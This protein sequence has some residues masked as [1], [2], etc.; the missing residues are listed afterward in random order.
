MIS[1]QLLV[2][3]TQRKSLLRSDGLMVSLTYRNNCVN[4]NYDFLAGLLTVMFVDGKSRPVTS[5]SNRD[6]HHSPITVVKW[7][8]SGK[9]LVTGDKV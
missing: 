1:K 3:G 6:Q 5:Y 8:P 4:Y 7:N 2:N 9:R